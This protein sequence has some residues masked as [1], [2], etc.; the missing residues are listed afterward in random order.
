MGKIKW[1]YFFFP[2]GFVV[3]ESEEKESSHGVTERELLHFSRQLASQYVGSSSSTCLVSGP[4]VRGRWLEVRGR[5]Q[6]EN[7]AALVLSSPT[8]DE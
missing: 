4:E 6:S 8:T 7:A 3:R 5:L 2:Q 1:V